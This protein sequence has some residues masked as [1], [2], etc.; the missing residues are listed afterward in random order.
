MLDDLEKLPNGS[1][2]YRCAFQVNTFD[3]VTRH[4]HQTPFADEDGYNKA[5]IDTCLDLD[6]EVIAIADHYRIKGTEKLAAAARAAGIVVFPAFE[7]VTREGVHF[8]CLFDPAT[9]ADTVQAR[10][11][12]CG[13]G[14]ETAPSPLGD[15]NAETLLG[16][17]QKWEMQCIAAHI[18]SDGGLFRALQGGQARGA[19]WRHEELA[20]CAIP[21]P[22][23]DT[24]ENLRP[25]LRNEDPAY[26]RDRAISVLN[27]NDVKGPDDLRAG[28][29]WC[30]IKM[31]EPTIEGLRQAFLDPGSRVRL[32]SD[33]GP[34]EH[35]EFVGMAWETEGF[36]RGCRLHFNE[37]LNVLIGGRGSGKS[38]VIESIRYVLGL[39]PVGEDAKKIHA[40]IV[41]GVLKSG[42]KISLLVQSYQPDRRRFLIERT[43]PDPPRVVD[44]NGDVMKVSPLEI[45]RGVTVFGQN[46]L[47]ELARSP[48]KLTA[49]L[50]RFV[51]PDKAWQSK[52]QDSQ[53]KLAQSRV[54][55]LDCLSKSRKAEEQLTALPGLTET[56]ERYREA[57]V[58]EKLKSRD[59]IVRAEAII[60]T[61][62]ESVAPLQGLSD[63][64]AETAAI[65]MDFLTDETLKG[66]PAEKRLK[67]LKATLKKLEAAA[68]K[69][70][71]DI[72]AAI[73]TAEGEIQ[74]VADAVST[75]KAAT[76]QAYEAALRELQKKKIDGNEFIRLRTE[77]ER[78]SPL[79]GQ[80]TALKSKLKGL[81]QKRRNDLAAWE[82]IKRERF[83]KLEQAAKKVSR[84][85]PDRLRVTVRYGAD[86][87]GLFELIKKKPGGR[88]AETITALAAKDQ[89]SL[90]ALAAAC[91]KGAAALLKEFA[92]PAS[93]G[94]RIAAAAPE[95]PMLFEELD[96][97]HITEIELNVGPDKA[98][99][100]WRKLGDLSTGQKA[101]ALLYLLLLDA[102]APL[103]LD[104]PEDNLDNRFIS[105]GV[106]PKIRAEKRRRQFIFSTHNANIPVLGDAELIVG[107]H[108]VGEAGDGH[109]HIPSEYMGSI[110]KKSV[111]A[112]AEEILEG[113]KEAFMTR[114]KKYNF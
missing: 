78:L 29:S 113:G 73:A 46:E 21:G 2:F 87:A 24:P 54:D 86:R 95:L 82:D 90:P 7:A 1:R 94:E 85:L 102:D 83:Q 23:E 98:P 42:T 52:H 81:E 89:L 110:D 35:V 34:E 51:A 27:C 19:I 41:S 69:A 84:E 18:A 59:S 43:V 96:L 109:A 5:L 76:Q 53:T 64:L 38:T 105:E 79:K 22:V 40:G 16:N 67:G 25:I 17:S 112:L 10:I 15:L 60:Q 45:V 71:S 4:N 12:A 37:N 28:G 72:S 114:R 62:R 57:G 100:E 99:A 44:E 33:P 56:L 80:R 88:V 92:I 31:T 14:S 32:A 50:Y 49:L 61:A 65:D 107:M 55:I 101:T 39:E 111:A 26:K 58:E 36:L 9:P 66:L 3:Y 68:R 63:E 20:A 77:I 30:L 13:I 103:V 97:P 104:Q 6:I 8:L 91:R 70:Q 106:V 108:A 74:A 75:E 48:E 47:A 93:Q 11:G